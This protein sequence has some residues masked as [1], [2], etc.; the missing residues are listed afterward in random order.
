MDAL[1]SDLRYALRQLRHSPGV[2]AV[3]T[4]TLALAIGGSTAIFSVV[5]AV[6]LRPFP[7]AEPERLVRVYSEVQGQRVTISVP[8]IEDWRRDARSFEELSAI[9]TTS[10]TL[11]GRGEAEE[12]QGA[13]V[14]AGF[15]SILR[16]AP[17]HGRFFSELAEQPG[18]DR[19]VVL[20]HELWQ[21]R[22]GEDPSVIGQTIQ[23]D[24][25][26]YEVV[27]VLPPG[28]GYPAGRELWT[29][30]AFTP[31]QLTT[32]RGAHYLAAIGRLRPGVTAEAATEEM[33]RIAARIASEYPNTNEGYGAVVVDLREAH[34]G[35]VRRPLYIL[36]GAVGLVVLIACANLAGL[37]L[38]RAIPRARELAIRSAVGATRTRLVRQLL[39]ES[40]VLA[41][42]G[43]AGGVMLASWG[44]DALI[45]IRPRDI[46]RLDEA[47]IDGAVLAFSITLALVTALLFG[48]LP[49]LQTSGRL[50]LAGGLKEGGAVLSG[51]R[52]N[53]LR[54]GLVVGQLA[55]SLVLLAAAG[56]VMRSFLRLQQTDPG[57]NPT[58]VIS[59]SI[60]L[61]DSRYGTPERRLMLV[62]ELVARTS[63]IPG[64]QHAGAVFG[65]PLSGFQYYISLNS[66]DGRPLGD[67][68][69]GPTVQVRIITPGYIPAVGMRLA[70]GR[71]VQP[72][73]RLG[74]ARV[75]IVNE[76][77]ARLLWPGDDPLGR[78]FELGTRFI[79]GG[80]RAGGEVVGVVR[81][82][83]D[84]GLAEPAGAMVFLPYAQNP[85]GFLS[86]AARTTG[87]PEL[88]VP[89]MRTRLGELD[90]AIAPYD[91]RTLE[92]RMAASVAGPKFY[93]IL[94]GLFAGVALVL[95]VLGIYG[96]M[97]SAVAQ[98]S[99]EIGIRIALGA[100]QSRVLR[101]VLGRGMVLAALGLGA[102][103]VGAVAGTRLLGTLLHE[104]DVLDPLTL[105][106][107]ALLLAAATVMASWIPARRAARV[108]PLVALRAE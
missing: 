57:F 89:A 19:V 41:L 30:A 35:D 1:W 108:D 38:T 21:R 49:A 69:D 32:Q 72:S 63:A 88:L 11:T 102:G 23:L 39:T 25:Q 16:T 95:A 70:R 42:L 48:L 61:P 15:L 9:H 54:N 4:L 60:S 3:A 62:E 65:L 6:L 105:F 40:V 58:Q 45:A 56:L 100:R 64:V 87:D 104:V 107:V 24:D 7:F 91:V 2:V 75:A 55:V 37:L 103:L 67:A 74:G 68:V 10:Y 78:E 99:R 83:R 81:D 43:A 90:P 47:R 50:D 51:R 106:A 20:G 86:V 53:R 98:R 93:M 94:L 31:E 84:M 79:R 13:R 18:N 85:T 82:S 76:T 29:P 71:D 33:R 44:T 28:M 36:F 12:L 80:E 26:S 101:E 46:P 59:Y 34:V 27:G 73:D 5:N 96:V 22:F 97:A 66:L 77:A 17:L 52:G 8:D 92:Q 14:H